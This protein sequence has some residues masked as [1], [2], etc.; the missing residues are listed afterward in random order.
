MLSFFR[1]KP[2]DIFSNLKIDPEIFKNDPGIVNCVWGKKTESK[3]P[4]V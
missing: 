4:E 3:G 2:E 1:F